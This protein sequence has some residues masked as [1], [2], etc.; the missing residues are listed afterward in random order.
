MSPATNKW[1][2]KMN[3]T[4]F[5]VEIVADNKESCCWKCRGKWS[6]V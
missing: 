3:L 6:E 1:R 5:Y 2:V 4:S